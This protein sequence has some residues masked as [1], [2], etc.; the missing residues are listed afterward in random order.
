MENNSVSQN[1]SVSLNATNPKYTY[2]IGMNVIPSSTKSTSFIRN[3]NVEGKD[4]ILNQIKERKVVNYSPQIRFNYRFNQQNNLN[5]SYSGGTSQ[6]SV[7]QLDPTP[8]NTNPLNIYSGNPNLLPS[9]RNSISLSFNTNHRE[10]QRT[11]VTSFDYGFTINEIINYTDYESGTGIQYTS[12]INEN[13][14][15]NASGNIMYNRPIDRAKKL[16]FNMNVRLGYNN[17]I[18]YS[19]VENKSSRNVTGTSNVSGNI[20]LSYN[21]DKY[22]GQLNVN[23]GY[24]NTNSKLRSNQNHRNVNYNVA[25]NTRLMLPW[26]IDFNSDVNYRIQRGMSAGYNKD[27]IL[28]NIGLSRQFL[29][30]NMGT[31]RVVWNDIL[32]QRSNISRN[33]TANYIEDRE[34]NSLTSYLLITFLYRFNAIGGGKRN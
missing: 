23:T 7:S 5:F 1:L 21:K 28:W 14:S 17:R 27:I 33:V 15:W 19:T 11:V 18:G 24:S 2:N 30:N 16:R 22:N 12:P 20:S 3:G 26:K 4:S 13:G 8:N 9:F 29:K 25:Y 34:Y 10:K 31:L 6:P 32:Q